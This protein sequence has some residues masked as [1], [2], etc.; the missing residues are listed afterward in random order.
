MT[1]QHA[2]LLPVQAPAAARV[3]AGGCA[4]GA[5]SGALLLWGA[6]AKWATVGRL[7]AHP[8]YSIYSGLS[9]RRMLMGAIEVPIGV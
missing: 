2:F 4:V 5:Y 6:A 3:L 7:Q 8:G 9:W 1:Q